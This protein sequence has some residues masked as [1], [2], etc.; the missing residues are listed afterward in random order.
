MSTNGTPSSDKPAVSLPVAPPDTERQCTG[1]F[2]TRVVV[3]VALLVGH[4]GF[5]VF[6]RALQPLVDGVAN[7]LG[8]ATPVAVPALVPLTLLFAS[9]VYVW[10]HI[11][12]R[13]PRLHAPVLITY[14]LAAA[15]SQYGILKDI[16]SEWLSWLTVGQV[17]SYSPTYV[18][19]LAAIGMELFL[20]KLVTGK[21]PHLASAYISG[22][23]AGILLKSPLVWPFVMCS[24]LAI[25]S[26]Y[27]LRIGNRH[28][29]NPTNLA[30]T[31]MLFL[32]PESNNGLGFE[33]SNTIWVVLVIWVLGSL[34]LY[35]FGLIHITISF[36]LTFLPLAYLRHLVTGNPFEAEV[37]PMTGA[38][39][40]LFI[41]FMITD[42]K[43]ITRKKWSQTLV[44]VLI[45]VTDTVLRLV[46]RD[47]Y[48][49][50]HA[51]FIVGPTANLIEIWYLARHKVIQ[52]QAGPQVG[53]PAV[54][55]IGQPQPLTAAH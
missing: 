47:V 20:H 40:Q 53:S 49:L 43:T 32:A 50:F 37:A 30:M 14:I 54:V 31:F 48:S 19:I 6:G 24:F 33:F 29:W 16:N 1:Y 10:R 34:I 52:G 27:A 2:W 46:F 11:V 23:S 44:S 51:L 41:F 12:I 55:P 8:G 25:A 3:T 26:K 13:D 39:F 4:F 17:T 38:M 22:I 45:G 35:R 9:L 15:H 42:P 18:A 36:V 7:L 21:W 5:N 28:L